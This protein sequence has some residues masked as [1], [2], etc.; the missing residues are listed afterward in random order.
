MSDLPDID[1]SDVSYLAYYNAIDQGGPDATEVNPEEALTDGSIESYT[2][3]DNG[4]VADYELSTGRIATARI[5]TD[6]WI[7][8]YLDRTADYDQETD[9][10]QFIRGPWDF[11]NTW[12]NDGSNGDIE[13]NTLERAINSLVSNL[14]NSGD[15]DYHWTDVGIYNYEYTSATDVTLLS[16]G[17]DTSDDEVTFLYTDGTTLYNADLTAAIDDSGGA[18]VTWVEEDVVI[19]SFDGEGYG[20]YDMTP[21]IEPDTEYDVDFSAT[22]SRDMSAMALFLYE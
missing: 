5:K 1:T 4:I 16:Y 9:E 19:A 20:T 12:T 11:I 13:N 22:H 7:V 2:L 14:E 10:L 21:D 3:Y 6:G 18:E 17:E 8:V 15:I